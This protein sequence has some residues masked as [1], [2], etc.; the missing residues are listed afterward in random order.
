[1]TAFQSVIEL[2]N[3]DLSWTTRIAFIKSYYAPDPVGKAGALGGHRRLS[4]VRPSVCLMSRTSALTRKPKGL[5]RRNFAQQR[6]PRSHATPTLTS[7]SKGQKSRW[8]GGIGL[9][10]R[11]P[12][13]T[14][15]LNNNIIF[16]TLP[17]T[18]HLLESDAT[19]SGL[20]GFMSRPTF[21]ACLSTQC[22]SMS[23][24]TYSQRI[25]PLQQAIAQW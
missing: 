4:S 25:A 17:F 11:R 5:G 16:I 19:I 24:I 7:R 3:P 6:Y 14:A 18:Q 8:G 20:I 9:L 15:C 22:Q 12:S 10:W 13:R 1:M 2:R 23:L 21:V